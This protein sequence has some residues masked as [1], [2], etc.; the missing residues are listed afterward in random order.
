MSQHLME[1]VVS[2]GVW[3]AVGPPE[4]ILSVAGH[5]IEALELGVSGE[6]RLAPGREPDR[7]GFELYSAFGHSIAAIGDVDGDGNSDIAVG[8]PSDSWSGHFH[9]ALWILFLDADGDVRA[10]VE[11][12]EHAGRFPAAMNSFSYLGHAMAPLGDLNGDGVPDLVVSAPGWDGEAKSQG[13]CWVLFLRQDGTVGE[14]VELGSHE[15][16]VAAGVAAGHRLG[17]AIAHIGDLD[18][19]G[20][21]GIAIS[22]APSMFPGPDVGRSVYVVSLGKRG[23][24]ERVRRIHD[25]TDGFAERPSWFGTALA[26]V[27]D[28]DGDGVPEIAVSDPYC[29]DGGDARGAVWILFLGRDGRFRSKSKISD[30]SGAFEGVLSDESHFGEALTGPGDLDGDGIPDLIVASSRHL[31]ELFLDRTGTVRAHRA[32]RRGHTSRIG[33]SMAL[34]PV[35]DAAPLLLLGGRLEPREAHDSAIWF[36]RILPGGMLE[37][38]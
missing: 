38:R 5:R 11:I 27:G 25:L 13:G 14:A 8:C 36:F 37:P 30:W 29:H 16:L 19:D 12:S 18:G 28:L 21:M 10:K 3:S 31:W 23:E 26:V 20:T 24:V 22:D 1:Q 2:S 4:E 9:G 34:A 15:K 35:R 17:E 33:S 6:E 7:F 32:F